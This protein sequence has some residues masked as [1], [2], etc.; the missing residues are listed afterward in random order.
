MAAAIVGPCRSVHGQA[1][2]PAHAVGDE[3]LFDT[4]ETEH[5]LPENSATAMVQTDDGYLWFG[6]FGGLVRFDGVAFEVL[7][8]ENTPGLPG[9]GVA[10]LF[11]DRDGR[12]WVSTLDGLAV[13]EGLAW[14]EVGAD[15]GWTAPRDPVRSVA[16]RADGS[17]LAST[18]DGRV[19]TFTEGRWS[20]LPSPPGRS[21]TTLVAA[22]AE[23]RW[24]LTRPGFVGVWDD[25]GWREVVPVASEL[26]VGCAPASDG[27]VWVVTGSTLRKF[28]DGVEASR[29]EVRG[30]AGGLWSLTED[31]AGN[32]WVATH[33]AGVYRVDPHGRLDRWSAG[34]GLA[35]DGVRF[36]FEDRE[37]NLWVG[38]SG[39]GLT[40]F[41]ARRVRSY[42]VEHGI[43]ERV[44]N[45][46]AVDGDAVLV[47]TY[48]KGLFRFEGGRAEPVTLPGERGNAVYV[49]S[50][51]R[52][53]AGR[54]WVGTFAEGLFVIEGGRVRHL[55]P[56]RTGG[57]NTIALFED[58][59]GRIWISG[60]Q[61]VVCFDAGEVR[62]IDSA[63]GAL[64]EVRAF[65]EVD[66]A[67]LA[68]SKRA[69]VRIVEGAAEPFDDP[70]GRPIA[71]VLCIR[72]TGDAIWMGTRHGLIRLRPGRT[73]RV[74]GLPFRSV[75]GI[76]ADDAGYWWL[77]TS[78]GIVRVHPSDLDAAAD[79]E[80]SVPHLQVLGLADGMA[81]SS[82]SE[83]RQPVCAKDASGR[84]W[85][86]TGRGIA[87]VDPS[88]FRTNDVEP[89]VVIESASHLDPRGIR[90]IDAVPASGSAPS[91][92]IVLAPGSRRL[93]IG[94]AALSFTDPSAV[95]FE[96]M[97]EGL[98]EAWQDVGLLRSATYHELSP[99]HY[100]F[101]VRAANNDGVWNERGA[102]LGVVV[103]PHVWQTWWFRVAMGAAL[104]GVGCVAAWQAAAARGRRR[105]REEE[106][107]RHVV[108]AAPSAMVLADGHGR[109]AMTNS[110]AERDFAYDRRE[111]IGRPVEVLIP[112]PIGDHREHTRRGVEGHP[113]FLTLGN[114]RE[115]R[116]RRKDGGEFPIE[117]AHTPIR[118]GGD[119][120]VLLSIMNVSE[121][122]RLDIELAQQRAEL[123]HL[124]RT[125]MMGELSGSLAHEL[126]QPLTSI[127]SN[128]QAAQQIVAREPVDMVE[129][130]AILDDIV[131]QDKRAGD[132]I[133]R[134]RGLLTKGDVSREMID[135]G[136]LVHDVLRIL[137]SELIEHGVEVRSDLSELAPVRGDRVQLQQ[138][139]LNLLMNACDAM[140]ALSP[141]ERRLE[142]LGDVHGG[143]VRVG[144]R[145]VGTGVAP[146][147]V[148][149]LFEPFFTTKA[150]GMGLGLAVCRTI[151]ESHG[152]AMTAENNAGDGATF[153]FALPPA[154][155]APAR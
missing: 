140:D 123:A 147:V 65:A 93:E 70:D 106:T 1:P 119:T 9:A 99:G 72:P 94:Y 32:V 45:S 153:W 120:C 85:F 136:E 125:T 138:V 117:V 77:A 122:K 91:G 101:R 95:R 131:E 142:V 42:G 80:F 146:E 37:R 78:E 151:I 31:S 113:A 63:G 124:S 35:Y 97:L 61:D 82:C 135:L 118:V 39:G 22:D 71:D 57:M 2:A 116:G 74:E 60:G 53:R 127:L 108:E 41:K 152:G 59:S 17:M 58:A 145:D 36:V 134:L 148:E 130:R 144:V 50:V 89:P 154:E 128:A 84:L 14:R 98:D 24:W 52:D 30:L 105:V 100:S 51:L 69:V 129:V 43:E 29:M 143:M 12:L 87:T 121:R 27:G 110:Q 26:Q 21:D 25:A 68:A 8:P 107:F 47:G 88:S 5:G 15:E 34:H 83:G 64:A 18:F 149:R 76:V 132:I 90:R 20:R 6:T 73:D 56:A 44:V 40:R 54:I 23:G 7:T 141:E 139:L 112:E 111:L 66:G 104:V 49:Q 150:R 48:G 92:E 96:V 126:N 3:F 155:G 46:V 109:I 33:D 114:G 137:R 115:L 133:R 55:D 67:I 4:W 62:A 102:S 10:N 81:T 11:L 86:A 28:R 16:Q 75:S 38:T 79:D 13:R 103:L 19:M